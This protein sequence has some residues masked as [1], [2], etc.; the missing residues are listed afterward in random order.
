MTE[1]TRQF[2]CPNCGAA[3]K[4]SLRY[5][6]QVACDHCD[7]MVMLEDAVVRL[8]GKQG[9]MADMPSLLTLHEP[10][11]YQGKTY[12]PVGHIRFDYAH[13]F[14]DEW[15]AETADGACWISVDEGDIAIEEPLELSRPVD[16]AALAVGA[17]VRVNAGEFLITEAG[18][19]V[20]R[21]VRGEIPEAIAPGDR[22]AYWH[23]SGADGALVTLEAEGAEVTATRGRWLN[24]YAI[25]ARPAGR[26]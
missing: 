10:F 6:K 20:C 3:L 15:W 7:S 12:T 19:A 26:A 14:W 2:N 22:F 8:A 16:P 18:E 13:G 1:T 11:A 21:A 4:A 24:P 17:T 25:A 9:V 23:L 5:A